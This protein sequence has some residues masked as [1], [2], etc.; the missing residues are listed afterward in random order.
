MKIDVH[1]HAIPENLI[2]FFENEP[3]FGIVRAG[4]Y[5]LGGGPE[6]EME[7]TPAFRDADAKVANLEQHGLDAAIVSINP[8]FFHYEVE[9]GAGGALAEAVNEGLRALCAA[10]PDRLWWLATVPLQDPHRAAAMLEEQKRL[11][12]VG[13]EIGT[14]TGERRLDDPFFE[15]FWAAAE[16]L[17][18][19]VMLHPAY[20]HPHPGYPDFQLQNAVGNLFETTIAIERL[21]MAGTLDRHPGL[22][23][24]I[25]H[26]GGYFA[27]QHGRLRHAR[28]VRSFPDGAPEEPLAY[29]GQIRSDCLTHDRKALAFLIDQLGP[30]NILM[31]TDLPCDMASP[32]PWDALVAAAGLK[33]AAR[34]AGDNAAE[35][36]GLRTPSTA[37]VG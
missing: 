32:E 12:C 22:R 2:E 6:G 7:L 33:T 23:V 37:A 34:I 11:G 10:R 21:I 15:P 24:V 18:L 17:G 4:E 8:P 28:R 35:L 1:N 31:G 9:G 27:Y 16:G 29:A 30:E 14:S 3:V 36:F 5:R 26:S 19:P 20:Q 13:V 25:V